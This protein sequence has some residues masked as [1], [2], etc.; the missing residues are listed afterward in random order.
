MTQTEIKKELYKQKPQAILMKVQVTTGIG[1]LYYMAT[2][3]I[4][5][6]FT[7]LAFKV[8]FSE[9]GDSA[10]SATMDAKLLIRY[11]VQP[12]IAQP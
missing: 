4:P 9:L 6:G 12:E 1:Y 2:L 5:A 3:N 10:W 11:I 8:P 7:Y